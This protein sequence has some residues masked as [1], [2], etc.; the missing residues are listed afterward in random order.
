MADPA[1]KEM[2]DQQARMIIKVRYADLFHE[3]KLSPE[4]IDKFALTYANSGM[5]P[6]GTDVDGQLRSLLGDAGYARFKEFTQEVPARTAVKLLN[7]QLGASPLTDEQD[8]RLLQIVRAEPSNLTYGI[9]G[10]LNDAFFGTQDQI[11]NYV[12]QVA[13]SNQ[14]VVQQAAA[15]LAPDQLAALNTVLTNSLNFR[16]A[17]GAALTQKH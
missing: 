1:M 17:Q 9:E 11:D 15:F 2:M 8:A 4:Q 3:L 7:S 12:Q 13:A 16:I 10:D 14:R 6:A 5:A